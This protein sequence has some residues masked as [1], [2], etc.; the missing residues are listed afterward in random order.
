MNRITV[1]QQS[2]QRLKAIRQ[3]LVDGLAQIDLELL[4]VEE[5]LENEQRLTETP[6]QREA[7]VLYELIFN[8]KYRA[9]VQRKEP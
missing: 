8:P 9:N 5:R 2:L 1:L 4:E 7:R 6:A 3:K